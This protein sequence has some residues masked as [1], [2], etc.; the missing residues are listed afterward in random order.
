MDQ[1][2]QVAVSQVDGSRIQC[3]QHEDA[4]EKLE[5]LWGRTGGNGQQS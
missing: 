3:V 4:E 2:G 1:L 5:G